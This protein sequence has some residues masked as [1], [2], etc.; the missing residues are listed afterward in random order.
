MDVQF[1]SGAVWLIMLWPL[2]AA[3]CVTTIESKAVDGSKQTADYFPWNIPPEVREN[4][5][6][7]QN[8]TLKYARVLETEGDSARARASYEQV[9]K[10][11]PTSSEAMLGIARLEQLAGRTREAEQRFIQALNAEPNNP[12]TLAAVANYYAE[13]KRTSES[14]RLLNQAM[15]LDPDN[16]TYRYQLAVVLARSGQEREALPFFVQSVGLPAAHYNLGVI[17]HQRGD[18]AGAE[19]HLVLALTKNPQLEQAQAWLEEIRREKEL[20][21]AG[22]SAGRPVIQRSGLSAT[23]TIHPQTHTANFDRSVRG[24][25]TASSPAEAPSLRKTGLATRKP[26]PARGPRPEPQTA[27]RLPIPASAGHNP[28]PGITEAQWEQW[29]NQQSQTGSS[30]ARAQ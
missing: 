15:Q 14:I 12:Q 5:K 9:L 22:G 7:S 23:A 2:W 8:L 11:Q 27:S 4:A 20:H 24:K 18:S 13:T 30:P 6:P 19:D 26:A 21:L 3:G 25:S 16:K 10:Q 1:Q 29:N 28:P 17:A